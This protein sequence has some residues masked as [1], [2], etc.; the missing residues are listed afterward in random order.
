MTTRFTVPETMRWGDIDYR[1]DGM[2]A[3][4]CSSLVA[5]RM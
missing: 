3:D 2:A 5:R 4:A 1:V